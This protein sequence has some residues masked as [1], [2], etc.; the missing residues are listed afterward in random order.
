MLNPTSL[1]AVGCISGLVML[2]AVARADGPPPAAVAPSASARTPP[3]PLPALSPLPSPATPP[4]TSPPD[5][6]GASPAVPV[7]APPAPPATDGSAAPVEQA[8]APPVPPSPVAPPPRPRPDI[9]LFLQEYVSYDARTGEATRGQAKTPIP[10]DEL[11]RLIGRPDLV[12]AAESRRVERALVFTA[13]GAAF[14]AGI[15]GAVAIQSDAPDMNSR[16]CSSSTHVYNEEC[17]PRVRTHQ[18]WSGVALASGMLVGSAL[19]TWG[20][21]IPIDGTSRASIAGMVASYNG[22]LRQRLREPGS[23]EPTPG[24]KLQLA[25]SVGAGSGGVTARLTF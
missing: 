13:S 15:V 19:L 18:V 25:P 6:A 1:V 16:W 10:R 3:P 5:A 8:P 7:D 20:L 24:A 11:F 2:T 23:T 4:G 21:N 9:R 22:S 17:D 12:D 14:V